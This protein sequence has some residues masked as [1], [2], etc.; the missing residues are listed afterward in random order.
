MYAMR[1]PDM[2]ARD[3]HRQPN[4]ITRGNEE[5]QMIPYYEMKKNQTAYA[6]VTNDAGRL[7][8]S[9][10]VILDPKRNAYDDVVVHHFTD[11]RDHWQRLSINSLF[12]TNE[13]ASRELSRLRG[14]K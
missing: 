6:I 11:G 8:V 4:G 14:E 1:E 2:D 5:N 3:T 10:C 9:M 13:L 7:Q 12:E